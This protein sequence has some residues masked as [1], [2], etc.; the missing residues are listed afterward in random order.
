MPLE[1]DEHGILP[2][3]VHDVD[4]DEIGSLFGRFQRTTRRINLFS[5]LQEYIN[6]L[7]KAG[8]RGWVIVDGSFV[9][10]CIDEPDDIDVVLVLA[11]DW[12]LEAELRPFQY[13][14]VSKR[15]VKRN[16]PIEVF[17]ALAGSD[18]ERGWTEY[19]QQINV[20]WYEPY[21]FAV[22]S[23]KGVVRITL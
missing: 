15:D 16:F 6:E 2:V 14:L 8:I 7:R 22:G 5:K 1:L 19:F 17:P 12:D 23:R 21:G 20:K 13:N 11:Q 9:M 10:R 3:D 4:L 18:A